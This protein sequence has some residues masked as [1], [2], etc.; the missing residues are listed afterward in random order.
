MKALRFYWVV[1]AS[2]AVL[3]ALEILSIR[4]LSPHF[5]SSVYVWGSIIGVVSHITG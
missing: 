5:G 1:A 4:L 3:M 2:G